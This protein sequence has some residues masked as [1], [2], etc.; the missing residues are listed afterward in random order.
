MS[1]YRMQEFGSNLVLYATRTDVDPLDLK[2]LGN[3]SKC[4]LM[5]KG[6]R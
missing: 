6:R 5:R 3:E 4:S 1:R 2:L